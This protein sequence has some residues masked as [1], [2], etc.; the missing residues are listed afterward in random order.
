MENFDER[1][2]EKP[3][4]YFKILERIKSNN[5]YKHVE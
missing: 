4:L 3:L 5:L 2:D 1:L